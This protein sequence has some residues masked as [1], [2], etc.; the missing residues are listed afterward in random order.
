MIARADRYSFPSPPTDLAGYDPTRDGDGCSWDRGK[1]ERAVNFFGDCLTLTTGKTAGQPFRLQQWQA[2]YVATLFGWVR[3][4]KTRRYRES[5]FA[6]P[7]KN[8]KTETGSGLALYGLMVDG[9]SAAQV[10]SA[11]KNRDQASL[12]YEPAQRMVEHSDILR[13]R[14]RWIDSKKRIVF[15]ST[16]SYYCAISADAGSSHGKNPHMVLFDEVHTQ[17]NRK[18]YEGLKTGMGFRSQPLFINMTTAGTDRQSI[19]WEVWQ[20]ARNVRD[21]II[22]DP[23]FLPMIYEIRDGE[24]WDDEAVWSRVNPNLGVTIT[25]DFLREECQRAKSIP[26]YENTFRNLYLN[27]WTEQ[28]ER[29]FSMADWDACAESIP[30]MAGEP[31]WCGVDLATVQD[32]A[33]VVLC[34]PREDGRFVLLPRFYIPELAAKRKE[35][36]DRVPYRVWHK[37]GIVQFTSGASIDYDYIRA[38]LHKLREQYDIVEVAFDPWNAT[39]LAT[40]L[41]EQ[42]G[43]NMVKHG[44][45]YASMSS[46]SKDFERAVVDRKLIHGGNPVLRWMANNVTIDQDPAGNIKPTKE[47]SNGRI[48][49]IVA[50]IMALG[51]AA[52]YGRPRSFYDDHPLEIG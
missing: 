36:Y 12:L 42:D 35:D 10:Y 20:H 52:A 43:Y 33:A 39:Q 2:D 38:D 50:S 17:P 32:I 11:A 4:D 37:Q 3:P 22:R 18:L 21:G 1:A 15:P 7:R 51:R 46:P 16:S 26:A 27:E 48:D 5:L 34:F 28:A 47:R 30:D 44:Q 6:V 23:H 41:A 14:C 31:C 9:E 49:G 40:Q 45:G 25:L 24:S 29:W 8:G 13:P 19:C